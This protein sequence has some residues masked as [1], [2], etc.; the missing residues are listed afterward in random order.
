MQSYFPASSLLAFFI[1]YSAPVP[2]SK[3]SHPTV[4]VNKS[5]ISANLFSRLICLVIKIYLLL[6]QLHREYWNRRGRMLST[7]RKTEMV[8]GNALPDVLPSTERTKV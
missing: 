4:E 3:Q 8:G 7:Q 1:T 6:G 5:V 2:S